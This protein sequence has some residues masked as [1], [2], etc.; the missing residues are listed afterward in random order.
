[1]KK[2]IES[3]VI[4]TGPSYEIDQKRA[5]LGIQRYWENSAK[6][7][8][9]TGEIG[10]KDQHKNP[11]FYSSQPMK[12]YKTMR[13]SGIPKDN[14]IFEVESR[15]TQENVLF[16]LKKIKENKI[17]S[18]E[19]ETD[20][21]HAKRFELLINLSKLMRVYPKDF[22]VQTCSRGLDPSYGP[23]KATI[24]YL[25]ELMT[26]PINANLYKYGYRPLPF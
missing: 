6:K 25:K 22:E 2:T 9:I 15:N 20:K 19:I 7:V 23:L 14:F 16:L 10:L 5:K 13:L 21:P 12:I 18:M 17:S 1:M 8:F 3:V 24:A 4:P 11:K 26:F